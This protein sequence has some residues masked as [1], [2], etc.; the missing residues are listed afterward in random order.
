MAQE[1]TTRVKHDGQEWLCNRLPLQRCLEVA[2]LNLSD[3]DVF[4]SSFQAAS[5]GGIG[6]HRQLIEPGFDLFDPWGLNHFVISHHYAHALAAFESSGFADSSVIVCDLGGSTTADGADFLLPFASFT[7]WLGSLDSAIELRTECLSIYDTS[8]SGLTLKHR[9]FCIP[10]NAPDV[11]VQSASSLYDNVARSIFKAENAHGQLMALASMAREQEDSSLDPSDLF[12]ID[13]FGSVKFLNNWQHLVSTS[14][15]PLNQVSLARAA[16]TAMQGAL[17]QY[18]RLARSLTSSSSLA[19][20]GG[21]FLNILANSEIARSGLFERYYAPSAPH[22]AGI[23][24]GCAFAGCRLSEPDRKRRPMGVATDR[25]GAEYDRSLQLEAVHAKRGLVEY[26][27]SVGTSRVA[28]L[29]AEGKIV[30]RMHGRSEFGP[31]ALGGR[32]ILASPLLA[33]SKEMLNHIKG[34]QS[35]R[36]VAPI[37]IGERSEE[38]FE[39]PRHSPYMNYVHLVRPQY[40]ETFKALSHPDGSTRAQTLERSDDPALFDLL[41]AFAAETGY[42]ILVNTSLNGRSQPIAETPE[43]ALRFYLTHPGVDFLILGDL[44]VTRTD[45]LP[46]ARVRVAN[47]A[48]ASFIF[49]PGGTRILLARRDTSIEISSCFFELIRSQKDFNPG[50]SVASVC[51]EAG[52]SLRWE[53]LHALRLGL[54]EYT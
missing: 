54:L 46:R 9:Q 53:I 33:R 48:I 51:G 3:V 8:Q 20:S 31:R 30:A 44:L 5:P 36:P 11:F 42:P 40:R 22:D 35:W 13:Q 29:L 25:L 1:R 28:K 52:E 17:V 50:E 34:R 16:Q 15:D 26:E 49:P 19:V 14:I 32:S 45:A 24:V 12:E 27:E 37:V 10:H 4:V 38:F 7:A 39:G 18:A 2:G 41:V 43:D 6:L 21:V 47:D 23:A